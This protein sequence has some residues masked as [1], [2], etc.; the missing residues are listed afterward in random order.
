VRACLLPKSLLV[1]W[2]P[3][4][5]AAM[6]LQSFLAEHPAVAYSAGTPNDPAGRLAQRLANGAERLE[7]EPE[8]GYLISV[9]NKLNIPVA[10]QS[11]VFSKT[12]LQ[13]ER[14]SPR[15][16]RALFFND[17]VYVGWIPNAP[18]ME[19]ASVDPKLGT[20]FY[21]LNQ[22]QA[23]TPQLERRT[24]DCMQCHDG[25]ATGGVPGLMLR[26]VYSDNEGNAILRAGAFL[27]TD[28]SPWRERWGGWYVT[29]THGDQVHMGNLL[30]ANHAIALGTSAQAYVSK[31]NLGAGSNIKDIHDKF[32]SSLYLSP[33]SDI[34]ALLVF[35]HQANVHNLITRLS[36][37]SQIA[38]YEKQIPADTQDIRLDQV[39][40]SL[41]NA[42]EALVRA[43]FFSGE[44]PY[45]GRVHGTSDFAKTFAQDGPR[46]RKGRSLRDLDLNRRLFRYPLS[47]LVYTEAFDALPES[48]RELVYQRFREILTDTDSNRI[49]AHLSQDDRQAIFEILQDTKPG[50]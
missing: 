19:F 27:T 44:Q 14:I 20:I 30:A 36:Y 49:Y 24:T 10:S 37:E 21:T 31:L 34:V 16:P 39:P 32:D 8:H 46:D 29:G 23:G 9:L 41:R 42:I 25:A 43:M 17:D 2:V 50:F 28:Q 15:R 1:L 45:A 40:P 4:V 47:Y 38:I 33:Y 5:L 6:P 3:L 12:S 48:T 7:F 35:A 11:L 22:E 13:A 26:S 18:L